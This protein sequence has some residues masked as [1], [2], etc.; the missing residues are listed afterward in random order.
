VKEMENHAI[1]CGYGPVGRALAASLADNGIPS[2]V[3]DLNADTIQQL[4]TEGQ[5]ALFADTRQQEVWDLVAIQ[6]AR[7]VA[8]TFPA[9]P[10]IAAALQFARERNPSIA[11]LA[12]TKFSA[13]ADKLTALG[14]DLVILDEAESSRAVVRQALGVFN[15]AGDE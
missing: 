10:E 7:L 14:A 9:T 13:E 3:I 2:L 1:I 8:F 6:R 12:R 11:I 4:H 5:P 15:I